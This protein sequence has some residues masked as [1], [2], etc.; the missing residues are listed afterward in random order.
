VIQLSALTPYVVV[1]DGVVGVYRTALAVKAVIPTFEAWV[2]YDVT[3]WRVELTGGRT[4]HPFG[5]EVGIG[6]RLLPVAEPTPLGAVRELLV[7]ALDRPSS[8]RDGS[9]LRATIY[10]FA[11]HIGWRDDDP[12][13]C[14]PAPR[15]LDHPGDR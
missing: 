10:C 7:T 1:A 2:A 5:I 14:V 3:G 15:T 9:S 11:A 12:S 4:W 6:P 13:N 8:I